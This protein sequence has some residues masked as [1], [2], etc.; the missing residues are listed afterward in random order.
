MSATLL[1]QMLV[2]AAALLKAERYQEAQDAARRV[3]Q[4][5]PNNF[6]AFMCVGIASFH[7]QQV[8]LYDYPLLEQTH[9]TNFYFYCNY[10]ETIIAGTMVLLQWG[11]CEEAY[12]RAS[13]LKP[14]MPAPWKVGGLRSGSLFLYDN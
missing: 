13:D 6:Q 11:D 10:L 1:K 8:G 4:F 9:M 5:D 14:E 12:R 3:T 2:D 7:L